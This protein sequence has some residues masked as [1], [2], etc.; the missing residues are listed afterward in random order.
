M[1]IWFKKYEL[2]DIQ[3]M[4]KGTILE[5][6][7]IVITEITDN[8]VEGKMPVDN[9]TKQPAGILHGGASVVL[10]ESLGSIASGL[11][12]DT[13]RYYCV[14][15]DVN[16]NHVRPVDKGY[17]YGSAAPIHIGKKTHVWS[18]EIK[19]EKNKLVC[20]SRLTMAVVEKQ[21]S[22]PTPLHLEGGVRI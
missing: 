12:V 10:A 5:A 21:A 1:N 9:R 18:I 17:V 3:G 22:P 2:K 13:H 4:S 16:A 20:I 11:V 8:S 15:L 7:G 6:L 19:N 14:G